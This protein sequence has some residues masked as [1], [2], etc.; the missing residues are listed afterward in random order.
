MDSEPQ[1]QDAPISVTG[2]RRAACDDGPCLL[3]HATRALGGG[4]FE[5]VELRILAR[6]RLTQAEAV[7]SLGCIFGAAGLRASA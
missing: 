7:F 5:I 6:E 4:R 3:V 1:C 2:V